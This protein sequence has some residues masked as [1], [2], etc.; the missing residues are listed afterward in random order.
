MI[1][2]PDVFFPKYVETGDRGEPGSTGLTGSSGIQGKAG[3]KGGLCLF[4]DISVKEAYAFLETKEN[5]NYVYLY[6]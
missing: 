3:M 6:R 5:K 2:S 1:V 4:V